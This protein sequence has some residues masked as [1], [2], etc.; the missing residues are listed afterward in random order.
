MIPAKHAPTVLTPLYEDTVTHLV[1][2]RRTPEEPI[3]EVLKRLIDKH[4]SGRQSN[5]HVPNGPRRKRPRQA[6]YELTVFESTYSVGTL[7][8]ALATTL[9]VLADLDE[10]F[11]DR[12][13]ELGGRSRR[14]VA[15]RREDI[16]PGRPGLNRDYTA[17]FRTGWWM[18]T[19]YSR[20]DVCRILRDLCDAAGLKYGI[21][22]KLSAP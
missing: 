10:S 6:R 21:D 12:A 1:H 2:L 18:G 14:H 3:A 4:R 15:R 17:E 5:E 19:N 11:L 9:N 22:V 20:A 13:S 8:E 16:Y 7:A